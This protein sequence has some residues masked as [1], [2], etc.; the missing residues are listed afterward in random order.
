MANSTNNPS[1]QKILSYSALGICILALSTSAIF[2]KFADAPGPV[3]G[4]YRMAIAAAI[5]AP[6][7]I[8]RLIKRRTINR[9]NF[10]VPVIGGVFSG[11]DLGIWSIALGYTTAAN[12]TILGNTAPLW[13]ALGTMLFFREHLRKKFWVGMLLAMAGAALIIGADFIL[14]PRLGIGDSIA[15]ITGML[16]AGYY[17][18]AEFGR[19]S[20]DAVSYIWIVFVSASITLFF[21]NIFLGN[22]LIGY[23]SKTIMVFI[24]SAVISQLIGYLMSSYALGH[25]PASVVSVTMVGQPVVT[26][27]IAIPLLGEL[28][29]ISQIFG[30]IIAL[31]GIYLVN[32]S[33][34]KKIVAP[35]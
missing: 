23:D 26:A 15:I 8:Y 27:I 29:V 32:V 18:T 20:I 2:I 1:R 4:F 12:A 24:A 31:T 17:L 9:R 14:H 6:F 25:L 33:Q 22:S 21:L 3:T 19:R 16:Y 5:L 13:V 35:E 34:E 10:M 28:P 7:A 11:L 30:G